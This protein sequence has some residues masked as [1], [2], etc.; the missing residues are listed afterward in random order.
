[1][2]LKKLTKNSILK[3]KT[4]KTQWATYVWLIKIMIIC[5]DKKF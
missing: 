4:Q 2:L 1:M 3:K 5:G